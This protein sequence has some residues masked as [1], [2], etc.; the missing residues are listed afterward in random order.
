MI[1]H[2]GAKEGEEKN[3]AKNL[4][5]SMTH[6]AKQPAGL[7]GQGVVWSGY[8]GDSEATFLFVLFSINHTS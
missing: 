4:L 7:R 2:S 8:R 1:Q 6:G 5:S 3:A